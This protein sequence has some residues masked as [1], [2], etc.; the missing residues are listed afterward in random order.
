MRVLISEFMDAPAVDAL[1]QRF[2]V[3]YAPE[4]VEQR[5]ALLEA[6]ADADALIVRNRSQ[7]NAELLAA[8]PRL[9]AVGRLGVG[10]D[11]IDLAGCE[12][13]GIKVI[14]ATGANARAVAEYVIGTMLSLLR[15]AYAST[16]DVAAG[17]WPRTALSQGLEA[18]GR[19]LGVVGFG[20]IGRLA[21]QLARGLGMRIVGSDAALPPA[22]PAWQEA[23][24]EP[25]AL[26]ELLGQADVVTLHVPLTSETR[27][28]LDAARIARMR[29]GAILIN[30]SRGGIVDEAALAAALRAGRLRGAALDVFEQEPLPAGGPLADAPNL[31]LTPHIAGLT[32][33]A[34][35]RVSDMVAAGVTMALD[36]RAR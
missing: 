5:A 12:A 18:H 29:P 15:G 30:T 32:Q 11:N 23:G 8:A 36:A 35:T 19:T 27:H 16:A 14:P 24:A 9:V 7:V 10:L 34:N 33:E 17:A 21:A 1:R 13:R 4:L 2:D 31:I 22:H 26:D 25:L 3:R 20:G 28:L 6:A